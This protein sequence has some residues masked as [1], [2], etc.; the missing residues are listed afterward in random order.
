M[1][2][3]AT[4][5]AAL[6]TAASISASQ[7]VAAAFVYRGVSFILVAIVGWIVFAFLFRGR[8]HGDPEFDAELERPEPAPRPE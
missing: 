7:A 4:L 2:V 8:Q 6:T 3:D 5:I 1:Y